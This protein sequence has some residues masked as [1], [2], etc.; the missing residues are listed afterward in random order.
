MTP[1]VGELIGTALLVL[2]GDGIVAGALLGRS[3]AHGAGW[4][5]ITFGWA[6]AVFVGVFA[7][8][9][10][11]SQAHLNPAVTLGW[12]VAEKTEWDLVPAYLAGQVAGAFLGAVLVWLA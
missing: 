9:H 5:A 3:K 7:A 10:L 12:A 8:D 11:G 6:V 1:F 4:L 2:L